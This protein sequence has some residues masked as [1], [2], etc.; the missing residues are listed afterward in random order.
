MSVRQLWFEAIVWVNVVSR[1]GCRR[2]ANYRVVVVVVVVRSPRVK[3]SVVGSWLRW[4]V[5]AL[6]SEWMLAWAGRARAHCA[7]V[8]WGAYQQRDMPRVAEFASVYLCLLQVNRLSVRKAASAACTRSRTRFYIHT[9]V[10]E[11]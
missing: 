4:F 1:A 5:L 8:Y 2:C 9:H 6:V 10:K 11:A 7:R 3:P